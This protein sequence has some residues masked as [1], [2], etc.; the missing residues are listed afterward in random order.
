MTNATEET[1]W[2]TLSTAYEVEVIL[3]HNHFQLAE[4]GKWIHEDYV[5]SIRLIS[6]SELSGITIELYQKGQ[7]VL[8]FYA[9]KDSD[10]AVMVVESFLSICKKLR[11]EEE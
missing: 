9:I 11:E 4:N 8:R 10:L 1:S 6:E 7:T 3:A 5:Q 2:D